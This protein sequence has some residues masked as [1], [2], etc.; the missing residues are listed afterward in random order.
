MDRELFVG[1]KSKQCN[2]NPS[3]NNNMK[4]H[5]NKIVFL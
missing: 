2:K 3:L 4:N 1:I 5:K